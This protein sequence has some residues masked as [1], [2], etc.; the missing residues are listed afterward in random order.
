MSEEVAEHPLDRLASKWE[1]KRIYGYPG[2]GI[3]G[4]FD[5]LGKRRVDLANGRCVES[6]A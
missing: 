3:M 1:V 5:R 2:D 6:H 4:V